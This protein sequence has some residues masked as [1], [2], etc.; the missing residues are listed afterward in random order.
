[1]PI[2]ISLSF[3]V[4]SI[5][6][7]I[8]AWRGLSD[9]RYYERYTLRKAMRML[10]AGQTTVIERPVYGEPGAEYYSHHGFNWKALR[11][12]VRA[13]LHVERTHFSPLGFLGGIVSSQA[14]FICRPSVTSAT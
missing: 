12:R 9:Y 14:W 1:M 13:H 5:V 8:A 7:K 4:K 6:R 10:F 3:F 2:E 11:E